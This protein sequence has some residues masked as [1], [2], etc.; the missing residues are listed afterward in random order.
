[1]DS[2]DVDEARRRKL[3]KQRDE[4]VMHN[5]RVHRLSQ[6]KLFED[7]RKMPKYTKPTL[8]VI[9][10]EKPYRDPR[11]RVPRPDFEVQ[12]DYS[13]LKE[14]FDDPRKNLPPHLVTGMLDKDATV[15]PRRTFSSNTSAGVNKTQE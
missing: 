12:G 2:F 11:A 9:N 15:R 5:K 8:G 6:A 14:R 4:L 1:M 13:P 7:Y 3:S 10:P